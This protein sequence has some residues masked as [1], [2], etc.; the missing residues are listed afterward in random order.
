MID[1]TTINKVKEQAKIEDV[2]KQCGVELVRSGSGWEGCCPFH[3]ER[4]PSFKVNPARG[5]YKCFGCQ[6]SGDAVTFVMEHERLTYP[7]A[8][9]R[10]A[11]MC[12]IEV[13]Y[14]K[15]EISDE[16]KIRLARRDEMLLAME[17]VQSF[18]VAQLAED[19][20]EAEAA[21]K[22][23]Y[24]RWGEDF[25]L[26]KGIGY[27]PKNS[28]LFMDWVRKNNISEDILLEAGVIA[29]DEKRGHYYASLRER[30]TIPIKN[31]SRR[32][33][34][35]TARY[36]GEKEA[37]KKCVKYLNLKNS[38]VYDKSADLFGIDEAY[39]AAN[40]SGQVIVV[41]GGPD[42]LRM[43]MIGYK[44]TVATLGT[45]MTPEHL[46][47]LKRITDTLCFIPDSDYR[48]DNL[49]IPAGEKAVRRNG[50]L[51]MKE[52]FIVNVKEIPR[53]KEDD[54]NQVKHDADSYF[55]TDETYRGVTQQPFIVW[56]MK[57]LLGED[58]TTDQRVKVTNEIADLL[59]YVEDPEYCEIYI[60]EL[61]RIEGKPKKWKEAIKRAMQRQKAAKLMESQY[62]GIPKHITESMRRYG[63]V[64][65]KGC[66]K[67]ED[68]DEGLVRWSNFLFTPVLHVKS[69]KRSTR[70]LK[71]KNTSG[72]EDVIE[73]ASSDL[74]TT[75]D[76][77]KKLFD[78]GNYVWRGDAKALTAMQ[79]HILEVTPSANLIETLGW[80]KNEGFFA[81]SN[82]VYCDGK[83]SK[84]DK[85]GVVKKGNKHFFLPAFSELH[86]DNELGY[87]FERMFECKPQGLTTMHDFAEMVRKV[88]GEG[89]M[90][91]IAWLFA[92]VFRDIIFKRFTWFPV[93]NIFGRKGSGK[94]ELGRTL[95]S[96]F[97]VLKNAPWSCSNTSIPV[98]AYNLS[99]ARN[100]VFFLDEYTNDLKPERIDI[101]KGLWG[102]TTR[103]KMEDG[104]P[105]TIP[106]NSGVIL[107]GQYK[108][109]D[110]A[111]FSRCIHLMYAK[112][113]WEPQERE[114]YSRL[115]EIVL[116]GNTH[117]LLQLLDL[118]EIF[119]NGFFTS[120]ELSLNDVRKKLDNEIVEDRMLNN[121]VV[122]LA[123]FR[124]L[125]PHLEL[126]FGYSD[127]LEVIVKGIRYQNDQAKK[128][129]DTAT[130]WS[131]LGDL[132]TNGKIKE[133]CHY[134]IKSLRRFV[135]RKK[136]A[137]D[138]VEPK[139]VLFL[140]FKAVRVLLE[141]KISRQRT[142]STLD[143]A[144]LESYLKSLPQY[145]GIKQQRFQILKHNGEL[146]EEYQQEG[147]RT[148]A[149]G[150]GNMANALCFDYDSLKR[151]LD[152]DLETIRLT[153]ADL[154]LDEDKD[155]ETDAEETFEEPKL[156]I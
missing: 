47:E 125:E 5:I 62:E 2:V 83:F 45:A 73:F 52:G 7:E 99:H 11:K 113:N 86:S 48:K 152:L 89:G 101:L 121:W 21:R 43:Q 61:S 105:V 63:I 91:S 10:I 143:V 149:Y 128:S 107:A 104:I 18:F 93:L 151:I 82:G 81:F 65:E 77:N 146:E 106:V 118:R 50:V 42:V 120:F 68:G 69:A 98:M 75:R 102:G 49:E 96:L 72:Q 155:E 141:Q 46:K 19:N 154:F 59:T 66:Y 136:E 9:E 6:K 67:G 124:V 4:T 119:E 60:T 34:N 53:T 140:N 147:L 39:A 78:T 90:I 58:P 103:S 97:Y 142:G 32:C 145:M 130:F 80:D 37:G 100:A 70:I 150:V 12:N 15:R 123:A 28:N 31:R 84:T 13:K 112:T 135:P 54:D 33:I 40:K 74:V 35:F 41:E 116:H 20:D 92:A 79:E 16:E 95:A 108:P 144:T 23:A 51:A 24:G 110:E 109:E 76:F 127:M 17:K 25:C 87:S 64:A 36:M 133:K 129:S 156:P 111:I 134:I 44:N 3:S 57:K 22:Y 137:I 153:D 14:E 139:R 148:K 122:A 88:Y 38:A 131:W 126:P 27:A 8:I 114:N 29:K 71:I 115:Q 117:L 26:Q 85:L 55:V 30:V 56:Y 1:P 138:F 132:Q 94:T